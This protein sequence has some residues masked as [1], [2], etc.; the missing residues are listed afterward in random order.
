MQS[1][2]SAALSETNIT[3]I[4][5]VLT[6]L[7]TTGLQTWYTVITQKMHHV[8]T[9]NSLHQ[10]YASPEMLDAFDIVD[11]FIEAQ[12]TDFPEAFRALKKEKEKNREHIYTVD[13]ARRR[14]VHWYS[15]LCLFWRNGLIPGYLVEKFPGK[16]RASNFLS[17]FEPLEEANTRIYGGVPND[18]FDCIRDLYAFSAE[19][20]ER[21]IVH[22]DILR[23]KPP[24]PG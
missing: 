22:D 20:N 17:K 13:H 21:C 18:T 5:S 12:G 3:L 14:V 15:K 16:S 1:R 11:S 23:Q 2:M 10:E 24:L 9:F 7:S 6:L 4:I 8:S 19:D